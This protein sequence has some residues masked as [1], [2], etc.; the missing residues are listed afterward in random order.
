MTRARATSTAFY[1]GLAVLLLAIL[2]QTLSSVMPG[3]LAR[4]IGQNSEA[5]V[6][7]LFLAAW[8]QLVMPRIPRSRVWWWVIP[9]GIAITALGFVLLDS[10]MP[11]RIR[12]LN[13]SF[14]ALGLLIPYVSLRRPLG[15]WAPLASLG[16]TIV[17]VVGIGSPDS[18]V[19]DLAEA[20]GFLILTPLALDV[21]DRG[22]LEPTAPTRPGM[23]VAW[24]LFLLAVP[25]ITSAIG[26]QARQDDGHF[27]TVLDYLGRMHESFI[28]VLI[29]VVFFSVALGRA[30]RDTGRTA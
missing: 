7:A 22:I 18:L 10:T 13:E 29:V 6:F 23:R 11:A 15:I 5:Y 27:A 1:A 8:I 28:G 21:V 19:V 24:Y 26:V 17:V 2:T 3:G 16:F 4:R 9:T 30:G 25:V 12:T 14:I 20:L